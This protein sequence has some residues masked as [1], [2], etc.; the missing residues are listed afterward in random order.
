MP[1][2]TRFSFTMIFKQYEAV[3]SSIAKTVIEKRVKRVGAVL[4][5]RRHGLHRDRRGPGLDSLLL[6]LDTVLRLQE[7]VPVDDLSRDGR[8]IDANA[9]APAFNRIRRIDE[10]AVNEHDAG[11]EGL[12]PRHAKR[13]RA[14][15]RNRLKG[16]RRRRRQRQ[17]QSRN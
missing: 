13:L 9:R 11:D 15:L 7:L 14:F 16:K 4:E 8:L 2:L 10:L 3:P 5:R 6:D 1:S 12:P 17:K